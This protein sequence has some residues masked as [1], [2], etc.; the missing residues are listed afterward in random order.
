ML[1]NYFKIALRNLYRNKAFSI[2]NISGLTVGMASAILILLWI[3][4]EIS[5][6]R[7]FKNTDRIYMMY[8]RDKFD[9]GLQTW[10]ST[11][12][13]MAAALKKDYPEVEDAVRFRNVTFLTSVGDKHLNV[14]GA[15]ADSGFL[16][17]FSFPLLK[18]DP[19]RCLN[20]NYNIILTEK[21]AKK[22]FGN[23]DAMGKT[24]RIDTTE[25]FTVSGVLKDLPGNTQFNFEYLLPW[26]FITKLGWDQ[27]M[28]GRNSVNTYVLLKPGTSQVA[29]DTKVKN[30]TISHITEGQ[31]STTEVFTQPLSRLYLYS[32][33][34][35]GKLVD[36]RI[37]I[38][39][40]FTIIAIFILLIA[41]INFMNLSTARSEKRAK[42]VGIRKVVG[43]RKG[44]LVAQ[45]IGESIMLSLIAGI[46][47][48][49]IVQ[50][51]LQGFNQ[52]IGNELFI[53]FS[54]PF[55][56]F[57]MT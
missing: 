43:S 57:F 42:E 50:F 54:N 40:L 36:G 32:K 3:Q 24:V 30:I 4:N 18:G 20:N 17:V 10:N 9:G 27:E 51:S 11:P 41:C 19:N 29:F 8:N 38:V 31:K 45:F 23:I 26:A 1:K 6:D 7:F 33:S 13:P 28:W 55:N 22:L 16:S 46:L 35:N 44:L 53:D 47:A 37:Q 52:L 5:Y 14:R 34:E 21:L 49:I 12:T 56:W 48:V 25:N 15:F 2:I 39:R